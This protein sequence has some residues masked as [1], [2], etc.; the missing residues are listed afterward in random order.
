M[1]TTTVREK[2]LEFRLKEHAE[3]FARVLE[4]RGFAPEFDTK[5]HKWGLSMSGVF[6]Q[7]KETT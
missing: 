3:T 6:I 1:E 5:R 4:L 7:K 2:A